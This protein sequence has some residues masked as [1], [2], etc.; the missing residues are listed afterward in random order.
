M[1]LDPQDEVIVRSTVDLGHN[2]GLAVVAEG[3]ESLDVLDRLRSIGCDVAQ[4]YVISQPLL[5]A[6][7]VGWLE[8]AATRAWQR[9]AD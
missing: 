8:G 1:L 7:L 3:V 4:G 5:A 2:L 6:E 9:A